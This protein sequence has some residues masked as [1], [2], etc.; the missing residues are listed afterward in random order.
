MK[1]PRV[2]ISYSHDSQVH[3]EWVLNFASRL[4]QSGIDAIL[5]LWELQPG[6]DLPAF[7]ERNLASADRILMICTDSYV[8]KANNGTGGVGYEKMIITAGLIQNIDSNKVIPIIRQAGTRQVPTFLRTKLF[9]DFSREDQFEFNFDELVR[10]LHDAPLFVKPPIGGRPTFQTPPPPRKT[11]DP[12]LIVMKIAV[13]EYESDT[14][15]SY[16]AYNML[17][18]KAQKSG[19]SRLY[20]D[21]ILGD[22]ISRK[23]LKQDEH[24]FYYLTDIGR[25]YAFEN[26]LS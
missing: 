12:I 16:L 6:D 26:N 14:S 8:D 11:L 17:A 7:M 10:S 19:I 9:L 1:P 4:R 5:D 3:K 15:K 23:L 25:K 22:I 13:Q 21:A 2:F 24:G 20:F 18:Y